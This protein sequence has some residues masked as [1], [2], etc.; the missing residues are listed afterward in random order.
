M[1]NA[2]NTTAAAA[3]NTTAAA[4]NTTAAAAAL[5]GTA[6]APVTVQ[7]LR[8]W[9]NANAGGNWANVKIVKQA[10]VQASWQTQ[11]LK[12]PV[13]FGYNGNPNGTRALLQNNILSAPNMG[14][15]WAWCKTGPMAAIGTVK[16]HTPNNPV[17]LLALLNGGYSPSS[18]TWGQPFIHL[19]V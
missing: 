13:P 2:K 17:C 14:A 7:S 4:A 19:T 15:H 9:V 5:F 16:T 11:G 1:G 3:A 8:A 18:A 12:G 6:N 10:T